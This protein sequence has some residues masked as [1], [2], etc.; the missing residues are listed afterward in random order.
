[1]IIVFYVFKVRVH[2]Q[3]EMIVLFVFKMFEYGFDPLILGGKQIVVKFFVP[4]L[5]FSWS[6]KGEV[7]HIVCSS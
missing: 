2:S 4:I 7:V 3:V 6:D 1:M 5:I